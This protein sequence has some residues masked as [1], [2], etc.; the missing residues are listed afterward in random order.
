MTIKSE[1][2]DPSLLCRPRQFVRIQSRLDDLVTRVGIEPDSPID[3]TQVIGSIKRQKRQN[4][5]FRR[6]EV[7][8]GYTDYEFLSSRGTQ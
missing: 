1:Q 6:F 8:S 4:R 3:Y 2:N 7:H 5:Y